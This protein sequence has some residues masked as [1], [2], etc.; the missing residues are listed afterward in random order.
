MCIYIYIHITVYIC[1]NYIYL[2]YNYIHIIYSHTYHTYIYILYICIYIL[3]GHCMYIYMCVYVSYI[4]IHILYIYTY[5]ILY[6]CDCICKYYKNI[7]ISCSSWGLP[8]EL[9][10]NRVDLILDHLS[11]ASMGQM[12][13]MASEKCGDFAIK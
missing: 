7:N 2:L 8:M 9:T 5:Y 3:N 4:Y 1:T 6:V 13:Q 11:R 10:L 12:G